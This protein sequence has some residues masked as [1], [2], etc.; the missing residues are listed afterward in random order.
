MSVSPR[1][2]LREARDLAQREDSEAAR[3]SAISKAFY[4]AF[5]GARVFHAHL[6]F[7][8]QS[9]AN[10]GEHENL[11]HQLRHPDKRLDPALT[12]RSMLVGDLL[13]RLRPLRVTADYETD[14]DVELAAVHDAIEMAARLM[15]MALPKNSPGLAPASPSS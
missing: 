2:L 8:G 12:Q 15:N 11:I 1:D 7:P 10:V 14:V 6:P 3:R 13:L 4:A 9:K 5:H